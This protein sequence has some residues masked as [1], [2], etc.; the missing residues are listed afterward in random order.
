MSP[1]KRKAKNTNDLS[2]IVYSNSWGFRL[3]QSMDI[4]ERADEVLNV[5]C[6]RGIPFDSLKR[7]KKTP[8]NNFVWRV[9][10]T[11]FWYILCAIML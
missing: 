1:M 4:T 6:E 11:A 2:Q 5:S 7:K 8:E 9:F 3:E 10:G